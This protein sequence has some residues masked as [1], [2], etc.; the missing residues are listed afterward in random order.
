MKG[1][2]DKNG[3]LLIKRGSEYK[4]QACPFSTEHYCGQRCALFGEPEETK[5]PKIPASSCNPVASLSLCK[6]K[7]YF[8]VFIDERK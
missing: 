4:A 6:K 7:L 5:Q 8:D 3:I 2:I 1:R